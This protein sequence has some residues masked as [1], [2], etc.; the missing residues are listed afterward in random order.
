MIKKPLLAVVALAAVVLAGA[1]YAQNPP[2]S[3]SPVK[4]NIVSKL[5]VPGSNYEVLTANL[6]IAPG[7]KAGR[8]FHP[9]VVSGYIT[10]G[11]FWLAIDGQ[12]EKICKASETCV[13]PDRGIHNEGNTGTVPVKVVVTYVVEKGQPLINPVK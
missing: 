4:R 9:G 12:P 1:V 2:V 6:E 8:H 7:F 10:E 11:E 3:P 5:D 13:I